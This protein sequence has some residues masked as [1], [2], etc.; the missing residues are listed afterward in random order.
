MLEVG[1]RV[2][3]MSKKQAPLSEILLAA[4]RAPE[5]AALLQFTVG[6]KLATRE[7]EDRI[8]FLLR[9]KATPTRN[10]FGPE[11]IWERLRSKLPSERR[12]LVELQVEGGIVTD[13]A[14]IAEHVA[15]HWAEAWREGPP[16]E[17]Q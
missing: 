16:Q 12:S 17:D 2:L 13:P 6:D 7:L 5:V 15:K 1:L 14:A 8:E 10:H 11:G 4:G 3:N 9:E